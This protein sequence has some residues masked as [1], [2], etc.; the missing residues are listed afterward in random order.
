MTLQGTS[1]PFLISSRCLHHYHLQY[2]RSLLSSFFLVIS[3][4]QSLSIS[5]VG[6]DE[7][8][9]AECIPL[10]C[11][12]FTGNVMSDYICYCIYICT[13][14]YYLYLA[15]HRISDDVMSATQGNGNP[16]TVR[17]VHFVLVGMYCAVL[18]RSW[19]LGYGYNHQLIRIIS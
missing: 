16:C 18:Q 1:F 13:F 8:L 6:L 10:A 15:R 17:I 14:F 19:L 5:V 3:F 2:S 12:R 9:Q 7:L 4:K 11:H